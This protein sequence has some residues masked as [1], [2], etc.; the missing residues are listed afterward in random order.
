MVPGGLIVGWTI[1]EETAPCPMKRLRRRNTFNLFPSPPGSRS[2]SPH[3][4]EIKIRS[5]GADFDFYY[6]IVSIVTFMNG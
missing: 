2:I 3:T 1:S 4:L 5:L 6:L